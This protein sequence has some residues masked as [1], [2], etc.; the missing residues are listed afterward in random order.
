MK[1][2]VM[3]TSITSTKHKNLKPINLSFQFNNKQLKQESTISNF[4]IQSSYPKSIVKQ[5]LL[6]KRKEHIKFIPHTTNNSIISNPIHKEELFKSKRIIYNQND[7]I[8]KIELLKEEHE[9]IV[10]QLK[11]KEEYIKSQLDD[12]KTKYNSMLNKEIMY[13]DQILNY[14]KYIKYIKYHSNSK[15]NRVNLKHEDLIKENIRL[16][17]IILNYNLTKDKDKDKSRNINHNQSLHFKCKD[18]HNHLNP[19]KLNPFSLSIY[20]KYIIKSIKIRSSSNSINSTT[21]NKDN[22]KK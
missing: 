8:L 11:N 17:S 6:R 14:E 18:D 22:I 2:I 20:K 15:D 7:L 5:T 12:Y 9:S 21:V 19:N 10:N 3:N 1:P 4:T 13:K 16:N